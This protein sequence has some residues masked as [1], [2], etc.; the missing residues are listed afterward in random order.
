MKTIVQ[1]K[2]GV[3]RLVEF[4]IFLKRFYFCY[5]SSSKL[6]GIQTFFKTG[7]INDDFLGQITL[8]II[9]IK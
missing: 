5:Y 7:Q 9:V 2:R 3:S 4:I 6:R 8:D 1:E